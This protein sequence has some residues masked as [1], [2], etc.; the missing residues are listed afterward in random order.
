[1]TESIEEPQTELEQIGQLLR[2]KREQKNLSLEQVAEKTR[3]H[4]K[5]LQNIEEG[6][7][8]K[9]PGPVFM[10]GF[11]RTYGEFIGVE[12]EVLLEKLSSITE[13]QEHNN[14]LSGAVIIESERSVLQEQKFLIFLFVVLVLGGGYFLFNYFAPNSTEFLETP[15]SSSPPETV[16]PTEPIAEN[17]PNAT[18]SIQ[19]E[20]SSSQPPPLP[21]P[22][23]PTTQ[24][25]VAQTTEVIPVVPTTLAE[26]PVPTSLEQ[27]AS[28]DEPVASVPEPELLILSIK[29]TLS[30]W[31][32]VKIDE[33]ATI[34]VSLQPG[35]EYTLEAKERY[36]LTIG[37]T[38]GIELSLNG[39]LQTIDSQNE[40][41][42]NWV[43]DK[44]RL[45]SE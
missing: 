16:K 7:I 2:E 10:R 8:G 26:I 11:I 45:P 30:S 44:S 29:A 1:M 20:S 13:L 21:E 34:E 3:I 33:E 17:P 25:T 43:L 12:I 38:K 5:T 18:P 31:I 37:N 35:E 36:V 14:A 40:L 6:Q 23:P 39:I 15:Q 22:T 41:L 27:P 9:N 19:E 4:L 32:G 42:E 28:V 24:P